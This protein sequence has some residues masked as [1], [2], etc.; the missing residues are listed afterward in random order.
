MVLLAEPQ[1]ARVL[2]VQGKEEGFVD[3]CAQVQVSP[4]SLCDS[5]LHFDVLC[6]VVELKILRCGSDIEQVMWPYAIP[7][8]GL[9]IDEM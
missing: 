8:V 9:L 2:A 6:G 5:Q 3:I 7:L 1:N 4:V